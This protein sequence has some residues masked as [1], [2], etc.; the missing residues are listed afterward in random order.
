VETKKKKQGYYDIHERLE[1][2]DEIR[3]AI[4]PKMSKS[5]FYRRHRKGLDDILI[6]R[7]YW[8]RLR[9]R[10]FRYFTFG[11]FYTII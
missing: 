3:K 1:G 7:S 10:A 6:E 9:P 5:T 2:M 4:N 11:W 8:L